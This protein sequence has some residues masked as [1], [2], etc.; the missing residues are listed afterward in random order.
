MQL[1][2]ILGSGF[3]GSE[4]DRLN[5]L[6]TESVLCSLPAI[7]LSKEKGDSL[8]TKDFWDWPFF[9]VFYSL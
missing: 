2:W 1:I 8:C 6:G 7:K 5:F 3:L 4:V 9:W